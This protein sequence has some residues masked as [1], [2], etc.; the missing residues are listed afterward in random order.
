MEVVVWKEV[1]GVRKEVSWSTEG[2]VLEYGRKCVDGSWGAVRMEVGCRTL[3]A[4]WMEA[5]VPYRWKLA[6]VRW[7]LGGW[8]LGCCTMEI[9]WKF[10][11]TQENESGT[12]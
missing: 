9:G 4:R 8:K 10:G 5:G 7:K 3:E 2:S 6:V 11:S 1:C 12:D